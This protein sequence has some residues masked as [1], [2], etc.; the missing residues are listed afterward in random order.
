MEEKI[1]GCPRRSEGE[2]GEGRRMEG[3]TWRRRVDLSGVGLRMAR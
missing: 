2:S 3:W 1:E